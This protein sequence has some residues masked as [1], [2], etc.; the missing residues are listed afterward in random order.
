MPVSELARRAPVMAKGARERDGQPGRSVLVWRAE[1]ARRGLVLAKGARERDGQPEH[2][3]LAFSPERSGL[4]GGS[5]AVTAFR[6][7]FLQDRGGDLF[8]R[9]G[10]R[11][12]PANTFAAH[13][14]FGLGDFIQ[15]VF[16]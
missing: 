8:D 1:A 3:G 13:Q 14:P 5:I 9:F 11:R 4:G 10:R 16:E 15:A 2:S 7:P 12:Q 6:Q